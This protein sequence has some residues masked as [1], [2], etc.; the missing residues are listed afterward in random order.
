MIMLALTRTAVIL[1]MSR[2]EILIFGYF[3]SLPHARQKFCFSVTSFSQWEHGLGL[4]FV[5][6]MRIFS[7][8]SEKGSR[9]KVPRNISIQP[10]KRWNVP[11]AA[12]IPN[13]APTSIMVVIR[14][15][16]RA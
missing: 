14:I 8:F 3:K 10:P 12:S 15:M 1:S 2:L 4:D 5:V 6:M 7:I 11:M 16:L 9:I 13:W